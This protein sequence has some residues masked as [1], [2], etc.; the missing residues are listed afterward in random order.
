MLGNKNSQ[1]S[2]PFCSLFSTLFHKQL[3]LAIFKIGLLSS[4][5][6]LLEERVV[7]KRYHKIKYSLT[8]TLTHIREMFRGRGRG[9]S[10][11]LHLI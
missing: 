10:F 9:V 8:H 5:L 6:P 11:A 7:S 4:F 2:M 1:Y 3:V